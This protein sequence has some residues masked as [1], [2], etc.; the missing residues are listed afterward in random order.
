[1]AKRAANAQ[2]KDMGVQRALRHA[3]RQLNKSERV[4]R[5]YKDVSLFTSADFFADIIKTR[6]ANESEFTPLD[7]ALLQQDFRKFRDNFPE[8]LRMVADLLEGKPVRRPDSEIEVAYDEAFKRCNAWFFDPI[9]D[10]ELSPSQYADKV[11]KLLDTGVMPTFSEF[12]KV[13]REQNPKLYRVQT[14]RGESYV[15]IAPSERSLRRSLERFGCQ[16]RP[17]KRGRPKD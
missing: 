17:D 1:M 14:K 8:F 10:L 7:I 5:S 11:R 15:G 12:E 2:H 3:E 9:K 13:F 4:L 16:T 6:R